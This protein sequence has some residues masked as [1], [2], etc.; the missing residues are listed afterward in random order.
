MV[1]CALHHNTVDLITS[2]WFL[3]QVTNT[4]IVYFLI[5]FTNELKGHPSPIS[6][7]AEQVEEKISLAT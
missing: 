7:F 5:V 3:E 6:N 4:T 1:S 2:V